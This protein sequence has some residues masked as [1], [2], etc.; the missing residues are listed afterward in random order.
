MGIRLPAQDF[1]QFFAALAGLEVPLASDGLRSSCER[2]L[3]NEFPR[4]A[5]PREEAHSLLMLTEAS[6]QI[7]G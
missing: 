3:M 4:S 5:A 7:A 6:W 2:L 1:C